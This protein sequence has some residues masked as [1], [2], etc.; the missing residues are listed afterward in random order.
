VVVTRP[1]L[2]LAAALTLAACTRTAA[3]ADVRV[4]V[5]AQQVDVHPV[6]YC[7]DGTG[8]R[9]KTTPPILEVS[10]DSAV[11]LTVPTEVAKRGWSVQVFDEK[12]V[13]KIG[14]VE[15]PKGKQAY[16]GINT[17]DVVPPAYY[18]VIVEK[19]GGACGSFSGAW[20]V[21]FLRAGGELGS[22]P[23]SG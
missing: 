12:L 3:P 14:E 23:P 20:P 2:A 11:T 7:L 4:A 18:L 9:Y 19:K 22:T 10:P 5:G 17:S 15:V 21:G 16:T 8:T 1:V 13:K 6:Q